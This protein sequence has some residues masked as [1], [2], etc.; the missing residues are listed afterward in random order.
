MKTIL[1]YAEVWA[2]IFPILFSWKAFQ[3][4]WPF[5]IVAIYVWG[6]FFINVMIVCG[7]L[8]SDGFGG[9]FFPNLY[10]YNIHSIF[11]LICFSLFFI[12]LMQPLLEA[13]KKL[14]PILCLILITINFFNY[15]DFFNPSTFS[16]RLFSLE[17][18]LL[19]FYCLQFYLFILKEDTPA[20]PSPTK[21]IVMGLFIYVIIN[22]PYF[23][24]F[25]TL[26]ETDNLNF[27]KTMWYIHNVTYIVLC[28]YITKAFHAIT[29]K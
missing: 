9:I 13:V 23:L 25:R 24:L 28:L 1:D 15:E 4:T 19:L 6:A 16:S 18:A 22:F 11:R 14:L 12:A 17:M 8:Y 7:H 20:S 3:A 5:K 26:I 10:L 21:W 29:N 2:L 27:V